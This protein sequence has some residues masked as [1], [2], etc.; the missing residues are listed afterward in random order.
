M[1]IVVQDFGERVAETVEMRAALFGVDVVR[2]RVDVLV[3]S[4]VVLHGDLHLVVGEALFDVQRLR[5]QRFLVA[6]EVLDEIENTVVVSERFVLFP[7]GAVVDEIDG[8][9]LVQVRDFAQTGAH[10]VVVEVHRFEDVRVG[11]ERHLGAR[12]VRFSDDRE[13]LHGHAAVETLTVYLAV[14]AHFDVQ[15]FGKRVDDG[16]ADAV[17]TAGDVISPAAELAAGV[18][19]RHDDLDGGHFDRLSVLDDLLFVHGDAAAVVRHGHAA[20]LGYFH[21]AGIAITRESFV[22]G[23]VDDLHDKVM[24]AAL[25]R[26]ADVHSGTLSDGIQP[27]EHLNVIG[28]ITAFDFFFHIS[29]LVQSL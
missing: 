13:I 21:G 5:E 26:R 23:V 8:K 7:A 1:G 2:V 22:D 9:A 12:L 10:G 15:P 24:Q 25:V 4:V 18:K 29:L 19:M 3:I 16:D 17:Q 11:H 27:F 14:A 20:V 28:G 6:V